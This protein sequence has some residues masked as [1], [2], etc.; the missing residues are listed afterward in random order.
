MDFDRSPFENL[1]EEQIRDV[2]NII[3]QQVVDRDYRL[4]GQSHMLIAYRPFYPIGRRWKTSDACPPARNWA[5]G[6]AI[7][8]NGPAEEVICHG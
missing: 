5:M 2:K 8:A 7:R 6:M 4:V 1:T 3:V